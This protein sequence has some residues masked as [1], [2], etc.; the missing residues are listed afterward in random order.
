MNKSRIT[1]SAKIGKSVAGLFTKIV[2]CATLD[3]AIEFGRYLS[4]NVERLNND[5]GTSII[6][7]SVAGSGD[8]GVPPVLAKPKN[9]FKIMMEKQK[10]KTLPE[11]YQILPGQSN[12]KKELFNAIISYLESQQL[13]FSK[14]VVET[15]GLNFVKNLVDTFWYIDPHLS[16]LAQRGLHLPKC[17]EQF[18]GFNNPKDHKPKVPNIRIDSI[19]YYLQA[20]QVSVECPWI[21]VERWGAVRSYV[22]QLMEMLENYLDMLKIKNISSLERHNRESPVRNLMDTQHIEPIFPKHIIKP[23]FIARYKRLVDDLKKRKHYEFIWVDE[24]TPDENRERRY[25]LDNIAKAMP[26]KC[27]FLSIA[28]GNNLGTFHFIW[29]VPVDAAKGEE[30]LTKDTSI[31]DKITA[32]M[33]VYHTRFMRRKFLREATLLTAAKP[34]KLIYLYKTLTGDMSAGENISDDVR[35][36]RV[37]TLIDIE[38]PDVIV[39]LREHNEGRPEKYQLFFEKAK[40]YIDNV[41]ETAVPDR[42]HDPVSHLATAMSVK[43]FRARISETCPEGTEIPSK[44]WLRLQF[45]PKTP[46]A[47]S[48][49]QFTGKL[50]VRFAVQ[51]RQY[52]KQHQDMHYASAIFR[53][54]K[55]MA[56][57]FREHTTF[58]V[59]DDKHHCKV[60]EPDCP[61]AAV[62]RGKRVVTTKGVKFQVADHDFTKFSIVPSV[63]MLIDIPISLLSGSF[64]RGDVFVGIK[65]LVLEPSSPLRHMAELRGILESQ[66]TV[67]PILMLYTDG[68][69][70]HRLTYLSV[71][72]S[73]ICLFLELDLD[74]LVVVRTPPMASW[75]NPA[76]RIMSVLNL[77]LQCVG[78]ARDSMD[79]K[80]ETLIHSANTLKSMREKIY[81]NPEL[82]DAVQ[83][84]LAPVKVG[85]N[86][87][88]LQSRGLSLDIYFVIHKYIHKNLQNSC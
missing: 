14:D 75:K 74:L 28:K 62:D 26:I 9:A 3:E 64:Y 1:V 56:V 13:L 44:Q 25:Y 71:K 80:Y 10:Q 55:E 19:K 15:S 40:E 58:V 57:K 67:K 54:Q 16:K 48:S 87:N 82:L 41:V 66:T 17:F 8:Q 23:T 42:R 38:D 70:D 83:K 84:S 20:L 34:G 72:L 86:V 46:T 47:R 78:L 24:Y 85:Q 43:D 5:H 29:P 30:I 77:A 79:G 76:E 61:V 51:S 35:R 39:D 45:A 32:D 88:K 21:K 4:F 63:T 2:L 50:D 69:P 73:L 81:D 18:T 53:Y 6:T 11:K 60:G 7:G 52:R 49:L 12:K 33:P 37:Q 22:V 65:D 36:E 31:V 68:G 59:M 27:H